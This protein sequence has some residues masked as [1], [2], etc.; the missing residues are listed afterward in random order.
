MFAELVCQSNFSFLEG[1]SHPEEM[2][3][4][5]AF[6]GYPALAITDECSVA[7]V[8]RAHTEI[9]ANRLPVKLI[10]GSLFNIP[11]SLKIALLCPDKVAYSELCRI[12]TNARRRSE[13]GQ[14]A[15]SQWD[16]KTVKSCLAIW[17]P[18]YT[19]EDEHWG[20]FFN[21]YFAGR[22]WIG[23]SRLL[24]GSDA[25]QFAAAMTLSE[26]LDLPIVATNQVLFHHPDRQT[27]QHVLHAIRTRSQVKDLGRHALQ[28]QERSLKP[29]SK[30]SRLYPPAWLAESVA[31]AG[32]CSFTLE[33]LRYQYPSELVPAGYS[34][35][36]YL[37]HCVEQGIKKRFP[38]G[39]SSELRAIIEKELSLINSE[40]FEYFFLT[41]YDIVQFASQ[42]RILYQGRGSA[43]NSVVCYCLEI[44]AVDPRQINVLFERFISKERNEPPDIDVDFEHERREEIIQYI[45]QKYGRERTAL[46]ASVSTFRFKSAFREVGKALGFSESRLSYWLKQFNLRDRTL[47]WQSQLLETGIDQQDHAVKNLIAQ[48]E[49]LIGFPRHLSQHVGGFVISAGPLY[50]LVPV[51]NAAM[52]ERTVIQWD[53]DDLES[54]GLLK[55]DVLALGMLTAIRKTFALIKQRYQFDLTIPFISAHGSDPQVFS[56]ICKA[57][58]VGVFQIESRAQMSMLP[59]LR[60]VSYYD[61]VVQ[62]AIVRPGPIQGEMVH[63]YLRRRHG[64]EPVSYPS[65]EVESVLSRT[66]GVPIFQEQV[67]QLAMVAAGFTGGEADQLR[68]AMASWK[69]NG[70]LR[71]FRSKLIDGMSARGYKLAFAEQLFEQICGFGEYGFPESHSASFAVL[72][73]ASAW[74]KYYFPVE[75]YVGL[76]NSWPMGFY[77]PAQ[78]LQD[79]KKHRI[80][81]LPVDVNNS[82]IDHTVID[83]DHL[84]LG[85]RQIN[86]L[87]V[88]GAEQVVKQRPAAGYQTLTQLRQRGLNQA[89]LAA[90]ASANALSKFA[91][92][93]FNVRWKLMDSQL[94]LPLLNNLESTD[95]PIEAPS[96]VENLIE[97][98]AALDLSISEHPIRLLLE[99]YTFKNIVVA[100]S[101]PTK[102]HK[103]PVRVLGCVIG[104]QA[105]GSAGGVTFMTLEDHTGN[106]NIVVWQNTARAQK[107]AF[108]SARILEVHGILERSPEGVIHVIA[109]KLIDHSD[110]FE[111]LVIGSRDFH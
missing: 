85:F 99:R 19:K 20:R 50:E 94:A 55:V 100:E 95:I 27:T 49:A 23:I 91:P 6:L 72:A 89:D 7:G 101:L 53:K 61:L 28:N 103:T 5:A 81:A 77:S 44:T 30:L 18:T 52:A 109:G 92:D 93:R 96:A 98:Y 32:R 62:I 34:A 11:S 67:I 80:Y 110:K 106:V 88:K 3:T 66:M 4:T 68:R 2:V 87:S 60:P 47:G 41:I 45:Y 46:A 22:C 58:T 31:I 56:A 74:L 82:S 29:L 14:Y 69:K 75:F 24:D 73:Y 108:I 107:K 26:D 39:L 9:K 102:S 64:S 10:V 84:R 1:A 43:A 21:K 83:N 33:E 37:R 38:E 13:K 71:Q 36:S 48:T 54:L 78:L 70:K 86:G 17:L 111:A 57:D 105:P 8:V 90:L 12:I 51:E 40:G 35:T 16:L 104:R 25:D 97:D 76:L 42:R 79:A 59:R 65:K 63:P 15:L